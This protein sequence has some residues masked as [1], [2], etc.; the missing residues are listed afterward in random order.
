MTDP[1]QHIIALEILRVLDQCEGYMLK[2]EALYHQSAL[3]VSPVLLNSEFMGVL[4]FLDASGH[5]IGI[6]PELGPVKWKITDKGRAF[7]AT[8]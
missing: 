5:A 3:S 4:K 2:Q 1:R 7:L 6:R 8:A